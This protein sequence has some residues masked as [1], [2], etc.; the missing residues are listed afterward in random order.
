MTK[1]LSVALAV[2][3]SCLPSARAISHPRCGRRRDGSQSLSPSPL[4]KRGS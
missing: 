1:K 4:T 2:A 3:T